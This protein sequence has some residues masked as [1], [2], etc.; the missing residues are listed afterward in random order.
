MRQNLRVAVFVGLAALVSRRAPAAQIV[1]D[2]MTWMNGYPATWNAGAPK[3]V[4]DGLHMYAVICGPGG[5]QQLCSVFRKRGTESWTPGAATFQSYQPP[6]MVLDRKGRLNLFYNSPLLHHVRFDHPSVDLLNYSEIP[7]AFTGQVAYLHASYDA[8]NDMILLAFN[9]T[10]TFTMYFAVKFTDANVSSTLAPLPNPVDPTKTMYLYARTLYAG[11]RYHVLVGEH[12]RGVVNASYVA[13]VLLDSAMPS[14]PW[15]RRDLH[16][17]TGINQGVPYENWV[18]PTDLQ[19]SPS[20]RVRV[21]MHINESNSGHPGV[22]EGIHIAREEDGYAP[23]HIADGIDDAFSL[24]IDP[25]S[26]ICLA[27]ALRLSAPA[28]SE[29]G[30]LV[31]FKSADDGLT[32]GPAQR[33]A[34]PGAINPV[35]V[36]PRNGSMVGGKEIAFIYTTTADPPYATVRSESV[37]LGTAG[38]A[39]RYDYSYVDIDGTTD[40]IRFYRDASADRSY[41]YFYDNKPDGTFAVAYSYTAGN[42]YQV[43]TKDASGR[44]DF[45]NSDGYVVSNSSPQI[46]SYSYTD[47]RDGST[48]FIY[49]YR[50]TPRAILYWWT[51]D[52]D[53]TGNWTSTF[54]YYEGIYWRI[55]LLTST[56]HFERYDSTGMNISG[57]S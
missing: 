37:S 41:Y 13:A 30:H 36:E 51:R 22:A 42:Y 44:V 23:R 52:F 16:R 27:F 8:V 15:S 43:Y 10:S 24:Q 21:L 5:T 56:G 1:A 19:A 40:Y 57:Q 34:D 53:L 17:V 38:T 55:E 39:G 28:F 29:A 50:D 25:T 31:A 20:G 33:I 2:G 32:W 54:V 4:S 6:V 14:G 47:T 18:L 35:A 12:L 7:I 26:G 46:F 11:G 48:D 3:V 45:Y 9:E 49:I